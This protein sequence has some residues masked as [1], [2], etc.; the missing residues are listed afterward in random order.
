MQH[1]KLPINVYLVGPMGAG[2]TTIGKMLAEELNAVFVD[3]DKE[4]EQR[5]GADIPWIFDVEGESGFRARETKVLE[6][7]SSENGLVI[8]TGGGIVLSPNNR[9]ILK[10]GT[11]IYLKAELDQLVSRV[12]KD[13]KRPLLQLDNPRR[14]LSEILSIRDPLYK[15]V[16]TWTINTD[17]RPPRHV[18]REIVKLIKSLAISSAC[19]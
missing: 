16:A 13:K 15:E 10:N 12:G 2:K 6:D 11:C 4:V 18:V 5:A 8:S 1:G 7:L 9:K 19:L 17:V 14:V 3:T